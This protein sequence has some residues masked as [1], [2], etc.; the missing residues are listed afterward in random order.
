MVTHRMYDGSSGEVLACPRRVSD[1]LVS[2][3]V[4]GAGIAVPGAGTSDI[5]RTSFLLARMLVC[6]VTRACNSSAPPHVIAA[7]HHTSRCAAPFCCAFP[8]E[9]VPV[10]PLSLCA[11]Y[12]A[13]SRLRPSCDALS[14]CNAGA[15]LTLSPGAAEDWGLLA[16]EPG[17][18]GAHA[19]LVVRTEGDRLALQIRGM[20]PFTEPCVPPRHDGEP[21]YKAPRTRGAA[22]VEEGNKLRTRSGRAFSGNSVAQRSVA[23][24]SVLD[25]VVCSLAKGVKSTPQLGWI[26]RISAQTGEYDICLQ[27]GDT[28]MGVP[29]RFIKKA[30][31]RHL[32]RAPRIPKL[33]ELRLIGRQ[34]VPDV[35]FRKKG[36]LKA[37]AAADELLGLPPTAT[38]CGG[39]FY[40]PCLKDRSS[41]KLIVIAMGP[42]DF[43]HFLGTK[44]GSR[45][46]AVPLSHGTLIHSHAA[47]NC[48]PGCGA[49]A[50]AVAQHDCETLKLTVLQSAMLTEDAQLCVQEDILAP[51]SFWQG[52]AFV[53]VDWDEDY[54][55]L[56]ARG[57]TDQDRMPAD[58][59]LVN[60]EF[61][62]TKM[63]IVD[64]RKAVLV[65]ASTALPILLYACAS[66]PA[67][68]VA[69][70]LRSHTAPLGELP[71]PGRRF[72][73]GRTTGGIR[74]EKA[75]VQQ[76]MEI[77]GGRSCPYAASPVTADR[78]G[79]AAHIV[80]PD[81]D[82]GLYAST[83]DEF[84]YWT[85]PIMLEMYRDLAS[86]LKSVVPRG[87]RYTAALQS[88][89]DTARRSLT[90]IGFYLEESRV[91]GESVGISTRY[92]ASVHNDSTDL[93]FTTAVAGKCGRVRVCECSARGGCANILF[94][95]VKKAWRTGVLFHGGLRS[96]S[97]MCSTC[98]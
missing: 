60:V 37:R 50:S 30:H 52:A 3:L 16:R 81:G 31:R 53:E 72:N 49:H 64:A 20:W 96:E 56:D 55:P 82:L 66:E 77:T 57:R 13:P 48:L 45:G 28:E 71:R 69:T 1:M 7:P 22:A 67:A 25:P 79:L 46:Q 84:E 98:T 70:N 2:S 80:N 78:A 83:L 58:E 91:L 4:W 40:L 9:P 38:M 65:D 75:G 11:L 42:D 12:A 86:M 33:D 15:Y 87:S 5:A 6:C 43:I 21:V 47:S 54:M 94:Q 93:L 19:P 73:L 18:A 8:S 90:D 10:Q 34:S 76:R 26:A 35:D 17:A 14:S 32:R 92:R 88:T 36:R 41:G 95:P 23:P 24:L 62:A 63:V 39:H 89:V 97:A 59:E 44:L 29:A 27:N 68:K 74:A 51:D 85:A 61:D